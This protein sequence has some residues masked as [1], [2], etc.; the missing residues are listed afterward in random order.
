MLTDSALFWQ[1]AAAPKPVGD[2]SHHYREAVASEG[3]FGNKFGHYAN[4]QITEGGS[5]SAENTNKSQHF[6]VKSDSP[7]SPAQADP[8]SLAS[9]AAPAPAPTTSKEPE[10][11]DAKK[12]SKQG[13]RV[14]IFE[15]RK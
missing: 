1:E 6:A 2:A 12:A 7:S 4:E 3:S 9:P 8:A 5:S 14:H 15:A 13:R 10:P 11:K